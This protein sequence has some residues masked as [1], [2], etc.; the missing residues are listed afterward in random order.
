MQYNIPAKKIK[1]AKISLNVLYNKIPNTK[2][3]LEN[4]A[5]PHEQGGCGAWCCRLQTPQVLYSEFLNTWNYIV[6]SF[7]D[8][9]FESLLERCL[10]KYLYPNDDKGCVFLNKETNKCSQHETRP[11]NCRIYGITP[12]EE[13]KPR[14]ERLKVIYPDIKEQ[15]NLVSTTD[16]RNVTKKD[17]DNWW[18]ELKSIEIRMGIKNDL[19]NDSFGG[20]YR[21][22]HDHVLIHILG[23]QN[24][25]NLSNIRM[26]GSKLD[27]ERTIQKMML[28]LKSFKES[29]RGKSKEN[30]PS[31]ESQNN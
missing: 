10:R 8:L 17:I 26:N 29:N 28:V 27:K 25:S 20:S 21:T 9:D 22:Y 5:K 7:S 11:F 18:L 31:S 2:G 15:C 3:C 23:E 13:F 14:Y 16:G 30:E 19:I 12:E 1:Q 6:S 24:L 4:I